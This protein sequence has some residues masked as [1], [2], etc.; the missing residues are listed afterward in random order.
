MISRPGL[1]ISPVQA[2][3][4]WDLVAGELAPVTYAGRSRQLLAADLPRLLAAGELPPDASVRFLP[5]HD[6]WLQS[7]D[8]DTLLPDRALQ[9]LVWRTVGSPG[10]VL[11][12]G[13]IAGVWRPDKAGSRLRVRVVLFGPAGPES[14]REIRAEAASLAP[15]SGAEQVTVAFEAG[16]ADTGV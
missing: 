14:E 11:V 10:V 3:R 9:R 1:G 2:G 12:G 6:P 15:F 5:P 13:E 8:R 16:P 7:R 4:A